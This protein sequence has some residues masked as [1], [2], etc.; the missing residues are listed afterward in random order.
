MSAYP[1]QEELRR[2]AAEIMLD[3]ARDVEF[4]SISEMS[5]DE[6][7]LKNLSEQDRDQAL[8]EIDDLIAKAN[9]DISWE[10]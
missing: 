7:S 4:L 3:H 2:I 8:R 6:E 10:A 1:S 9:I 5:E